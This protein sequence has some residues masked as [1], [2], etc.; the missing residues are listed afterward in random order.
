MPLV[1]KFVFMSVSGQSGLNV[2]KLT[3]KH[4]YIYTQ[5]NLTLDALNKALG[6]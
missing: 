6:K 2:I 1:Y 5:I 3:N 4:N